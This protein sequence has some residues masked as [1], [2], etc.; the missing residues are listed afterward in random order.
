MVV[1]ATEH[2][3][4]SINSNLAISISSFFCP[5]LALMNFINDVVGY[6][7]LLLLIKEHKPVRGTSKPV[8]KAAGH[9]LEGRLDSA[10]TAWAILRE[11]AGAVTTNVR[12]ILGCMPG[13]P[14]T[15]DILI[16][17]YVSEGWEFQGE[18]APGITPFE[19]ELDK[20]VKMVIR[21]EIEDEFSAYAILLLFAMWSNGQLNVMV[22]AS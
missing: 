8:I 5:S 16:S 20:T 12:Q 7:P 4:Q 22:P 3:L 9:Y 21:G 13:Y 15:L 1:Q 18:S 17:F 19:V 11:E 2:T 10:E 14:P 6:P